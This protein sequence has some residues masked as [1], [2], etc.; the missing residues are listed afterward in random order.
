MFLYAWKGLNV[1]QEEAIGIEGAAAGVGAVNAAGMLL[2]GIEPG[3]NHA[4][5]QLHSTQ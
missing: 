5:L 4:G 1:G 2:V 3:L